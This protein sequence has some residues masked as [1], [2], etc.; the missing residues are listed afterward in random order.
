MLH[1]ISE[2]AKLPLVAT[3]KKYKGRSL[4]VTISPNPKKKHSVIKRGVTVK[5]QYGMLPHKVQYEYCMR[6]VERVY[7]YSDDTVIYGSWELNKQSNIHFH[8]ILHDKHIQTNTD[9][10]IFQRDVLNCPE[11]ILNLTPGK[12]PRDYMN[13]IVYVNKPLEEIFAY[14]EKDKRE[15]LVHFPYYSNHYEI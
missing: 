15:T 1:R 7:N 12:N 8:L 5:M 9:L 2:E 10:Q 11:V 3:W 6:A 13:N 4:F 14:I